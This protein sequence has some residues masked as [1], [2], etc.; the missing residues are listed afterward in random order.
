MAKEKIYQHAGAKGTIRRRFIAEVESITWAYKL[1]ELTINLEGSQE[2]PEVQVFIIEAKTDDVS[3][4]ILSAIDKAVLYP[5]IFEI[6]RAISGV[7]EVRMTAAF[8]QLGGGVPKLHRYHST[9]WQA[10]Q[11]VRTPLPTAINL[12]LLHRA[13]L[14]PLTSVPARPGEEASE[15][16]N[17]LAAVRRLERE[18]SSL[19]RQMCREPQFNRKVELRRRLKAKQNE[20]EQLR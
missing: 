7:P 15:F 13:L 3:D 9:G 14:A 12:P 4:M 18:V 20:L 19:E 16:A 11:S 6:T 17:R 2:V 1:A 8:K 10:A 5:V